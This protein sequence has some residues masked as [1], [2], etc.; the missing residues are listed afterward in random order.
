MAD[1]G[2]RSMSIVPYSSNRDVVLRHNDSVVVLDRDSQQ[3]VLRNANAN[4]SNGDLDLDLDLTDCP[5]CHRPMRNRENG[6]ET[7][8]G[9]SP[10][11]PNFVNPEYFRLLHDSA[12]GSTSTSPPPSP[13]RRFP[14]PALTD[15]SV[16]E[17]PYG[18][19]PSSPQGIS[20]AAF[21]QGYF[22]KFFIEERE[23][24]RGGKGVV[25]LVKHMLDGVSLGHFACKRVPVGDDHEW[26]EK[27]LIEVQL[28][29]H[30]SHQNLVSYRHVWLENAQ[31]STFSPSVP[32]AFILQQYCNA[33]DLHRYVFGGVQA[34]STPQQ[35]KDRLRRR[36]KGQRDTSMDQAG[37]RKLHFEEI[38]S[39]FKDIT[40][41]IRFLHAN[42]YIHRDLKPSNCLLHDSGHEVRVLVSDFGE[43]QYE[44]SVRNSTGTTGTVSY[45]APEVLQQ[46][47]P[48]GPFGNF[49]FKSDVFSMGMI[50][51]FLC[52]A[53]LPYRSADII[54]EKEDIDELR[55]EIT[56]WGGFD[57]S[58]KKLR[59]DF[60]D[61]LY[62]I[63]ERLLSVNPDR[64]PTADEVLISI[65]AGVTS[66]ESRRYTQPG[67][68]GPEFPSMTRIKPVESPAPNSPRPPRSPSK[69]MSRGAGNLHSV[70]PVRYETRSV[71]ASRDL[72]SDSD[73][74][75]STPAIR[76]EQD[77]ILRPRYQNVSGRSTQYS[78]DNRD[79]QQYNHPIIHHHHPP[80]LLPPPAPLASFFSGNSY[81]FFVPVGSW[82]HFPIPNV[83][84]TLFIIKQII[85][86]Q[87]CVP[88]AVNPWVH[89]PL[90]VFAVLALPIQ[91]IKTQALSFI[92]HLIVVVL[93]AQM[94]AIC[95]WNSFNPVY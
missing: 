76:P 63:L 83:R 64:R 16:P 89:Y 85:T 62:L 47:Y 43:V 93:S 69:S 34:S 5:Y 75:R 81:I 49:T 19:L 8:Q 27:V 88:L 23:L 52:F 56:Q 73:L 38:Y 94:G 70:S 6:S 72:P 35:L 74:D 30:L 53:Q 40:S 65:Q 39:F 66:N 86:L 46:E 12:P 26:L 59:P 13:H 7:H 15:G 2:P 9:T 79:N 1:D 55:A 44:Q 71:T 91:S 28:L 80:Q 48:D 51:H 31:I 87:I 78:D 4:A 22:K 68:N 11:Q 37:P 25:L 10:S 82:G 50:L 29:Q 77:L 3:L 84:F 42:G 33:G 67:S 58:L 20:S 32:C 60:P 54:E 61:K 36:S 21:S 45:C 57:E 17:H 14:P 92:I 41:G 90:V 18:R 95:I 24:G